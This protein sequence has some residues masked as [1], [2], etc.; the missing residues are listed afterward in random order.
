MIK[1]TFQ[2]EKASWLIKGFL[3]VLALVLAACS[4]KSAPPR[5]A[6]PVT[7]ATVAQKAVPY[8]IRTIGNIDAFASVTVKSQIGG[9][10]SKIHF[11]EGQFVNKGT[12]L[13]TID[14]RPLQATLMQAQGSLA[15]D[16]TQLNNAREDEKRYAELVKKGY[17][18]RQQYEQ[19]RA[20]AD[21]L[22]ATV[23]A[24]KAGVEYAKLQLSYCFIHSP[25]NGRAGDVLIDEGNLV[26]A[27]D[28]NK[29][30]TTIRQLQ[31]IFVTFSIPEK[32]LAEVKKYMSSRQLGLSVYLDNAELKPEKGL[33][34]F[35]DNSVDPATGT[36]KLKGTLRNE[37]NVLWPGQFV[38]VVL[39]LYTQQDAVVVPTPAIQVGQMGQYVYVVTA[40]LSAEV[41]SVVVSRTYMGESIIEKGLKPGERV[42]TD[43]QLRVVP[44]GKLQI[45]G[46]PETPKEG[47]QPASPKKSETAVP[48]EKAA[49]KAEK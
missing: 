41:R 10:L 39:S 26:K 45:K 27:S 9:V 33:L 29:Y 16:T 42:V 2:P 47:D 23:N 32:N 3:I 5:P 14:P 44:N 31:P 13:F 1:S 30:L 40:D 43:G 8:E 21:A 19:Q 22:E 24:D 25:I 12:L 28:D 37:K 49:E 34:T 46:E 38:N 6:A 17:I 48:A 11:K 36:I 4:S 35:I 7:V 15:R 18:S 20:V